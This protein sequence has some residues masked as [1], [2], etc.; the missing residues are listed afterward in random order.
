MEDEVVDLSNVFVDTWNN[1]LGAVPGIILALII[2]VVGLFLARWLAQVAGRRFL[3]RMDDPLMARFLTNMLRILLVIGALLLA[4]QAA[5]LGGIAAGIFGAA[6]L[7]AVVLGFAFQDIGE[8]FIAG[9]VMAFNRPFEVN[10]TI[11]V[12]DYFGKVRSLNLRFTHIKT[13]DGKDIHIPN[14]QVLKNA[15]QNYTSDGYM[16][17]EFIVGIAY[18]DSI[19][20]AREVIMNVLKAHPNVIHDDKA[21][22]SFVAADELAA[23]TIN[24]KVYFWVDTKDFSLSAPQKRGNVI[25]DV[26]QAI[27]EFGYSLPADITEVKLYGGERDIPIRV[28]FDNTPNSEAE[29]LPPGQRGKTKT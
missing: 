27:D 3:N 15:V 17:Y 11:R 7:G 25:R 23:S 14:A 18:E 1:F 12:N 20:G 26:K 24:L 22:L 2:F 4:L 19:D 5:G 29:N 6:G 13:F 10:D 16:R 8:N 28:E 9:I 21:H